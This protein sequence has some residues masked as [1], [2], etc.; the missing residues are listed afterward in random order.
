[1][2]QLK[3]NNQQLFE[4]SVYITCEEPARKDVRAILKQEGF[5]YS[6]M[7]GRQVDA[8]VSS[9]IS[10]RNSCKESKRGIPSD[11]VAAMFP[12]IS[13]ALQ[14]KDGFYVG[15]NEFPVFIDFFKRDRE[16]VNSNM[17]VIGKSG[18]G[19]SYAT[20][21]LLA[22]F[23]AD[24]TKIFI[25]D[26]ENE[27]TNLALNLD[28]KVI[29]V[30]SSAMGIINPFHVFTSLKDDSLL[31]QLKKRNKSAEQ[32]AEEKYI[33]E[34]EGRQVEEEEEEVDTSDTFAQHLQFLEQF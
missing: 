6:E 33:A 30:G 24:N 2:V 12:F 27:Y 26:P 13:S 10:M 7:F 32:I 34:K 22:N 20:K 31:A 1:M 5:K 14:D 23:A 3:N 19:K 4:T 17:M 21:T 11:S 15:D 25:L 9:N 28:G 8:F 16:R 29:D 18:S